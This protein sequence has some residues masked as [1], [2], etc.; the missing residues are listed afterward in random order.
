MGTRGLDQNQFEY[1][2]SVIIPVYNV[3]EYL[4]ACLDSLLAQ[5]IPQEEMEVLMINDG[6][7]DGSLGVCLRYA[8]ERPNF[9]V[10]SQENQGVSVA[11]NTGIRNARGRY[12]LYLDGDDLLSPETVKNVADFFDE[13]YDEVDVLTYPITF[14]Y[15]NGQQ[16]PHAH[17]RDHVLKES[18]VFDTE[19]TLYINLTTVNVMVKNLG[20][21]NWLYDETLSFHEDE[22][23]LTRIVMTRKRLGYVREAEYLY[24]LR[25]AGSATG[26]RENPYY[27]FED[28]MSFYEG[29]IRQYSADGKVPRYVQTVILND[30]EWKIRRDILFPYHYDSAGYSRAVAR[31]RELADALDTDVIMNCPAPFDTAHKFYLLSLKSQCQ[32]SASVNK[33]QLAVVEALPPVTQDGREFPASQVLYT[34][35]KLLIVLS[36]TRVVGDKL[37]LLAYLKHVAFSFME[38]PQLFAVVDDEREIQ[39]PLFP[40]QYS[41]Y[42]TKVQTNLFWAFHF[43]IDLRQMSTL[44]FVARLRD[45]TV[46]TKY[47]FNSKGILPRIG[48]YFLC[49]DSR[50]VLYENGALRGV[51]AQ[52]KDL[53]R[54]RRRFERGLLRHHPKQWLARRYMSA[55]KQGPVWLY[56]DAYHAV[57]NAYVQ[58]QH[59]F[60]KQDGVTR[61]Y[62]CKKDRIDWQ[63][64]FTPEQY[65]Y[66]VERDSPRHKRLFTQAEKILAAF[67]DRPSYVP[68]DGVTIAHYW[69]L[70]HFEVIYLQHGVMHAELPNMYS[71]EKVFLVDKIVASTRFEQETF[72]DKLA[73]RPQDVLCCGMPR[74]DKLERPAPEKKLLFAPSWRH[75]LVGQ[76]G[77][78]WA[79]RANF[80]SSDYFQEVSGFLTDPR[81]LSALEKSGYRLEIKLHPNFAMYEPDFRALESSHVAVVDRAELHTYAG[82]VT[83]VSSYMYDL[84][85]LGVPVF[86]H[87]F[88]RDRFKAGLHSYRDLCWP[89]ETQYPFYRSGRDEL[90]TLLAQFMD[91]PAATAEEFQRYVKDMFFPCADSHAEALY[92]RLIED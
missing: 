27:I 72:V 9:R 67:V 34:E 78:Q 1:R 59:D 58:F 80:T 3:E 47:W 30:F 57:D 85:Y 39:V 23:Y 62:V 88:D 36:Q 60:A 54:A 77:G 81:L 24:N 40:S 31:I 51:D 7:P 65:P 29:L 69:D 50:G 25:L 26:E 6:S 5:T 10:I 13:H 64:L 86:T 28:A 66:L 11:R 83:D 52:S 21:D 48:R 84:F 45:R 14:C 15:T 63:S 46:E 18:G 71:K 8:L 41:C 33:N 22:A 38:K 32:L 43:E 61:Y 68:F 19:E 44:R 82:C 55:G 17:R 35:N 20:R 76:S 56:T 75:Y 49:G 92:Q 70:F 4:E 79:R 87:I 73:F 12:L 53:R 16:I 91:A 37:Y 2:V 74:L 90:V 42:K 89:M